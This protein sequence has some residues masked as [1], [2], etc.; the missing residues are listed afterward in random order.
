MGGV[1]SPSVVSQIVTAAC[2]GIIMVDD[3]SFLI[4]DGWALQSHWS[5]QSVYLSIVEGNIWLGFRISY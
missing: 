5:S 2:P 4:D 3:D 1:Q